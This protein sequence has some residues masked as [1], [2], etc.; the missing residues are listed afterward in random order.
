MYGNPPDSP[1]SRRNPLYLQ[2]TAL[3]TFLIVA[4]GR[5]HIL[6]VLRMP[7]AEGSRRMRKMPLGAC[8]N[9]NHLFRSAGGALALAS[10][11]PYPRTGEVPDKVVFVA[12]KRF[13]WHVGDP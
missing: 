7:G 9:L 6:W 11:F 1:K 3:L 13:A 8:G 4:D 10:Q 2:R 5:G 12:A